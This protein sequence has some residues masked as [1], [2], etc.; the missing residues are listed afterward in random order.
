M[1]SKSTLPRLT[2]AFA[3]LAV[4]L[5]PLSA[6]GF[7]PP[8]CKNSFTEEQEI[9]EGKKVAAQVYQQMPVLRDSDPVAVYVRTL[10]AKLVRSTQGYSWPYNF[11][12]VS[13]GEINAF[14]LPGGSVFVNLATITAAESEAQLAGVMAHEISHV[15][16][17]H[18]TCNITKQ[19]KYALGY[20]LAQLGAGLL[21]GGNSSAASLSQQAIGSVAG[22]QFLH[23]SRDSEKQADLLGTDTLYDAGYDP[24]GMPQFFEILQGKY[25][26]GSAQFLSDHPNPG[27]RTAYVTAEIQQLPPRQNSVRT[28]TE[29][30]RIHA[31]A[32]ARQPLTAEQIKAGA[33]KQSDSYQHAPGQ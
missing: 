17:R 23:M 12:V 30:N 18:A 26:Q 1:L 20:G 16:M 25:G 2:C 19:Q 13:S 24:R 29:F 7:D 21:L 6:F 15:V 14:A 3:L 11:H 8:V 33:W 9:S 4:L 32:A 22:L 27:N 28:S 10:G 31:I 5:L